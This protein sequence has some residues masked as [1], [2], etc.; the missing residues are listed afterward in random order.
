MSLPG[1]SIKR[2][3]LALMLNLVLVLFGYIAFNQVGV[4]RF[5]TVEFPIVAISTTMPGANPEIIDA[6][7]TNVIETKINSIP[8]IEHVQSTSSPSLSVVVITFGLDEN[9]DVAFNDVQAKINQ[10]LNDLPDEAD[11]PVVAKVETNAQPIMWLSLQ[12]DRTLQQLNQYARNTVKKRLETIDGVGEVQLG[13]RRDRTIRVEL[14]PQRLSA[15][16]LTVTDLLGAFQREHVQLP[17]GFLVSE[18]RERLI[19][20]DLEFHSPE[21]LAEMVVGLRGGTPVQLR[22]VATVRDAL[23]DYRAVARYNREPAVGLGIVKIANTNTVQIIDA[24]KQRLDEE[25]R[26][27]LPPGMTISIAS[28]S[29]SFILEMVAALE[30]HLI[31]GTLLAALVVWLFL[32]SFRSTLIIATAIPVSLFGAV[33]VMFFFGYTI[34]VLTL[35]A[36]L[37][38]IGVVVDDAI[39]VLENIYRHREEIDPDPRRAALHGTNQVVFAVL[40]ATL[41]LVAIFAPVVFMGGI[42]GKFFASFGVVV[43]FGVL[44]SW[45]VSMTLTPM[46]ASRYLVVS[47][48]HGRVWHALENSFRALERGYGHVI[49]GALRFRWT[50]LALASLVV[51]SSGYFFAEVGKTFVPEED[52][53]I[54]LVTARTPLGSSVAYTNE[55][56]KAI[57]AVLA[58]QPEVRSFFATVGGENATGNSAQVFVR[59]Q[60]RAQRE[61]RQSEVIA[62]LERELSQLPGVRAFPSQIPIVGGARGEPLQF[63]VA[64]PDLDTVAALAQQL[65]G[66]LSGRPQLGRLDLDLELDLPQLELRVDRERAAALGLSSRDLAMAVNVLAGG[67]DVAKFSDAESD[68]ERYDI[69]L[70]AAEGSFTT[71]ADL[72]GIYLRGAGGEMVRLDTVVDFQDSIGPAV[73]S[74]YDLQYAANFF[75]TPEIPLAEALGIVEDAA[76]DIL[77]LG[78]EVKFLGEAEEFGKTAGYI[79]FAFMLAIVLVYM[80][81]ASQ[82][83]SFAQ[84]VII[85]VAQPLAMIGGVAALWLTGHT[86]NIF[87]MIGLVLL[88]GLV[89]KNSILLVDMTNQLREQGKSIDQALLE[90]CPVRLR[91]VL[92]TSL[93]VILALLPA[94]LGLGA[95]ADTNGPLSVAVIGGM[96]TSTALTLVVVPAVYSLMENGLER[97]R[98]RGRNKQQPGAGA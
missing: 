5:P 29:S 10:V 72:R 89:A 80:V 11:T 23:G 21:A 37:L 55:R 46:L 33:A 51:L 26:P 70:K 54:F 57:E 14:D 68:G 32:K 35:L 87:S 31:L 81:L 28:D 43:S 22:D 84:P 63:V 19:K 93:T 38:L 9:V 78:Y 71:P 42:I 67:L 86:L 83:N 94:A 97:L 90:A 59:L 12:G 1:L 74:R 58:E 92:M 64:G 17:G 7:I 88:V 75:G 4:D 47:E 13:G 45:L 56:L 6:S 82:F 96:L 66:R 20:L 49:R 44:V 50:V 60:P 25:I 41:T 61:A 40:A 8:G 36:L 48:Q 77:P 24:V 76:A 52:E 69:R 95:G 65:H 39:V 18:R 91:P 73:I 16:G 15:Y 27:Q 53:G 85:M 2:P 3:V 98:A 30:E 62:R 34:N 79:S